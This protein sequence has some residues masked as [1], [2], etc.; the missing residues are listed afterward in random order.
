MPPTGH[1]RL[2]E[3]AIIHPCGKDFGDGRIVNGRLALGVVRHGQA[4]PLHPGVEEPHDE[5]KDPVIAQFALW[6]ALG[7]REV[8]Q[9]KG[10]ELRCEE[11]DRNRRRCRLWYCYVDHA[12]ASCE[13]DGGCVRGSYYVKYYK[14]LGVFAKL[15]TSY[16]V[17]L[18][19]ACW[20]CP[21]R[22]HI[23]PAF[24]TL[25]QCQRSHVR[26]D[27]PL[28]QRGLSHLRF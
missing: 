2:P 26:P 28:I 8:R 23:V 4:L 14:R 7:H 5:V 3:R 11:L 12:R 13:E 24:V 25:S 20:Q 18:P 27:T 9:E 10:L 17:K 19:A 15:A 16:F 21:C 1:K 22:R 6:T